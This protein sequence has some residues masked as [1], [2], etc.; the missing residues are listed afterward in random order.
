M[1]ILDKLFQREIAQPPAARRQR[2]AYWD[3]IAADDF[4]LARI[5]ID[6]AVAAGDGKAMGLKG[7]MLVNGLGGVKKDFKEAALW[8]RQAAVRGDVYS[9]TC[10][11]WFLLK[12]ESVAQ[13]IDEGLYWIAKAARCGFARAVEDLCSI[14]DDIAELEE[15]VDSQKLQKLFEK[16]ISFDEL[17]RLYET[18]LAHGCP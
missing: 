4:E 10:L 15:N 5:L 17:S 2:P 1:S 13:D 11:G 6:K 14:H 16:H 18:V 8:F 9:Q 7:A 3:A 12:G